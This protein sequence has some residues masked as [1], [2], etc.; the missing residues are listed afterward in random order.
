MFK[1]ISTT[2]VAL[3]VFLG[4]N[5][6]A[7]AGQYVRLPT[8]E[9][10][11]AVTIPASTTAGETDQVC[12]FVNAP[13]FPDLGCTRE[14]LPVSSAGTFSAFGST[15]KISNGTGVTEVLA[16]KVAVSALPADVINRV[17]FNAIGFFGAQTES[18]DEVVIDMRAPAA[19]R[20]LE[21]LI[22]E[23][24]GALD[25]ARERMLTLE[26]VGQN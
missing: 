24:Q 8:G 25:R 18:T 17:R 9:L 4:L 11:F 15:I 14:R 22:E 5:S 16:F 26:V 10:V 20:G 3:S 1:V 19:P 21:V 12:A 6:M 7:N 2:I 13:P 23:L